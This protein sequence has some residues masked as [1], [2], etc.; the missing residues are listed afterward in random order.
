MKVKLT[1]W[2]DIFLAWPVMVYRLLK[3]GYTYRRIYLGEGQWTILDQEDYCRLRKYRW[4]VYG[5]G[6][7]LYAFR[8]KFIGPNTT[9][10]M[11]M[12]REILVSTDGRFVDHRNCNSLDNRRSNLRFATRAENNCNRRKQ[13][14][15][16][17]QY[18]GVCFDK[19]IKNWVGVVV[20]NKKRYWLGRFD[21]EIEA[22]KAYDEKAN[23][24]FGEFARLNFPEKDESRVLF[25]RLMRLIAPAVLL[26]KTKRGGAPVLLSGESRGAA[27]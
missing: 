26:C 27:G 23:Q 15:T 17:S 7:S 3:Y 4:I 1:D 20:H 16:T 6:Q 2:V 11:S 9:T 19:R 18:L 5:R 13:K 8:Y 12:H 14:N 24:L 10:M 25:A 21:S 22:A